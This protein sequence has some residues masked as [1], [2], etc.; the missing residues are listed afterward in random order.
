MLM[1]HEMWM[2]YQFNQQHRKALIHEAEQRR[3]VKIAIK[4][5]TQNA[6]R[7]VI[8]RAGRGLVIVGQRLQNQSTDMNPVLKQN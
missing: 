5:S 1:S 2:N 8:Y 6:L 4:G 7:T 3:L